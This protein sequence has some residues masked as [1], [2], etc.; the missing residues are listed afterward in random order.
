MTED[1]ILD[2]IHS[3]EQYT[4]S[5]TDIS[6]VITENF[7]G[8]VEQG[9]Q[10][11]YI[12][13]GNIV[14]INNGDISDFIN[15][16]L[17][18]YISPHSSVPLLF[19]MLDAVDTNARQRYATTETPLE[20][21]DETLSNGNFAGYIELSEEVLSGDY[22]CI[23]Y[24]DKSFYTAFRGGGEIIVDDEAYEKAINEVGLYEVVEADIS[25]IDL[26]E[27][28]TQN[29]TDS[30][31]TKDTGAKGEEKTQA[32]EI[33]LPVVQSKDKNSEPVE[34]T[35]ENVSE[36]NLSTR[37]EPEPNESDDGDEQQSS[38][39]KEQFHRDES[40]SE[41]V[42]ISDEDLNELTENIEHLNETVKEI[43]EKQEN[44]YNYINEL[45][46]KA[47]ERPSTDEVE[48]IPKEDA[49]EQT[50]VFI[51]YQDPKGSKLKHI[52]N[53]DVSANEITK[54]VQLEVHTGFDPETSRPRPDVSYTDFLNERIEYNFVKWFVQELPYLL[55]N[56][57]GWKDLSK[58]YDVLKEIDRF[59]FRGSVDLENGE[60]E[61]FDIVALD[62]QGQPL[63]VFLAD[64]TRN[65][66][67]E[68]DIENLIIQGTNV[69]SEKDAFVMAGAITNSFFKPEALQTAEEETH[70][71]LLSRTTAY[72][73]MKRN[74]G[75]HL[76]LFEGR[77]GEFHLLMPELE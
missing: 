71:G 41:V 47:Q 25:I 70:S 76:C 21:T 51:R 33:P 60:K 40:S 1:W 61:M 28:K 17:T 59:S 43:Q 14:G 4:D 20:T 67:T 55:L 34:N 36:E 69:A 35:E 48:K 3:W 77:H 57:N 66:I 16:E 64:N 50:N 27:Q 54:N 53:P 56:T 65:P 10:L 42:K 9:K 26:P 15:A 5:P 45:E 68:E 32:S 22:Y 72:V 75:F 44:I 74:E 63:F 62:R 19:A 52:D 13:N 8:V 12:V 18:I 7:N 38:H 58:V 46:E 49:L 39:D 23:Y 24:G 73:K 2:H 31:E 30:D 29:E 6:S 11:A 37:P